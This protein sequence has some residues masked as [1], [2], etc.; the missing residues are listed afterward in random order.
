MYVYLVSTPTF[1]LPLACIAGARRPYRGLG[2]IHR[3][4]DAF[5]C[6]ARRLYAS[7]AGRVFRQH[8][9]PGR[10]RSL[11]GCFLQS[12]TAAH[13]LHSS[14]LSVRA[15]PSR[16][17]KSAHDSGDAVSVCIPEGRQRQNRPPLPGGRRL[18]SYHG[19]TRLYSHNIW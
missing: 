15:R 12:T 16:T 5:R 8:A 2:E 3:A 1:S 11:Q 6:G 19:S 17:C 13:T 10:L 4:V 14:R 18:C 9:A 7:R